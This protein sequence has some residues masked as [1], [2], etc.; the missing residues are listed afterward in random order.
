ME[1]ANFVPIHKKG[2]KQTNK[3]YSPVSLL[4]ICREV[5]EGMLYDNTTELFTKQK[6]NF[7][8]SVRTATFL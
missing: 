1:K 3:D 7:S 5:S 4:A 8:A 6:Y 2:D